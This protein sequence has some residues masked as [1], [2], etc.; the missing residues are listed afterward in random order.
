MKNK[1]ISITE[2]EYHAAIKEC[3]L[4]AVPTIGEVVPS[5]PVDARLYQPMSDTGTPYQVV[6]IVALYMRD[7]AEILFK[8]GKWSRPNIWNYAR[9][10]WMSIKMIVSIVE[11][12]KK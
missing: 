4:Y 2:V 8:N 12:I 9:I 1:I 10:A 7:M 5:A 11:A 3:E 6:T